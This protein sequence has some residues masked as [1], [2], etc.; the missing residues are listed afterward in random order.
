VKGCLHRVQGAIGFCETFDGGDLT[1]FVLEGQCGARFYGLAVDVHDAGAALAGI[2]A[3]MGAGKSKV[4]AEEAG[5]ERARFDVGAALLTIYDHCNFGHEVLLVGGKER[6]PRI[7]D[8]DMGLAM[9]VGNPSPL[10][11]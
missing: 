8:V 7:G 9:P 3:H 11:E 2:A 4:F 1:A 6:D 10:V 5:E